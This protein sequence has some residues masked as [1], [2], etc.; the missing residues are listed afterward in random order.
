MREAI[1]RL[2]RVMRELIEA[3]Q[4]GAGVEPLALAEELGRVRAL[5]L[6]AP[7]VLPRSGG[8]RHFRCESCGTISHGLQAPARCPTCGG[9]KFFVADLES[10]MVDAGPA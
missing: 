5:M 9:V 10:P 7:A 3:D 4:T 6:E 2:D 1:E 8:Q